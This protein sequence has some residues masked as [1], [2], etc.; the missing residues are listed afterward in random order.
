MK[1]LVLVALACAALAYAEDKRVQKIVP[2]THGETGQIFQTVRDLMGGTGILVKTYQ[3][4]I[5][6]SGM[7]EAVAA[8][9]QLI[10]NLENAAPRHRTLEC[11]GYT[12][13]SLTQACQ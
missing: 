2:V 13:L 12:L 5:V 4:N 6:L 3:N 8:A 9:E 11:T 7:P 10:K 1:K